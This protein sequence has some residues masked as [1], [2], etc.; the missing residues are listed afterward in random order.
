MLLT[1]TLFGKYAPIV[2]ARLEAEGVRRS[3]WAIVPQQHITTLNDKVGI[4]YTWEGKDAQGSPARVVN[5][6]GNPWDC[7]IGLLEDALASTVETTWGGQ[8]IFDIEPS[9]D[10]SGWDSLLRR[11]GGDIRYLAEAISIY[12]RASRHGAIYGYPYPDWTGIRH[13]AA[14]AR[15]MARVPIFSADAYWWMK[16]D[17]FQ[18]ATNAERYMGEVW[19]NSRRSDEVIPMF[20]FNQSGDMKPVTV[21]QCRIMGDTWRGFGC[22]R[23]HIWLGC[24]KQAEADASVAVVTA[25]R[26]AALRGDGQ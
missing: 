22:K 15:I 11:V 18:Y 2:A 14:H 4:P 17:R 12:E 24:D 6:G 20:T 26:V 8:C 23:G 7:D 16:W 3:D 1:H 19:R 13:C 10:G 25:G 21:E 5:N 9:T